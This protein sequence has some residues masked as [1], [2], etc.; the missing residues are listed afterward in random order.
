MHPIIKDLS[1]S[2]QNH[3]QRSGFFVSLALATVVLLLHFPFEGY[4]AEHLV[5]TRYGHGHCPHTATKEEI[6]EFSAEQL[7]QRMEQTVQCTNQYEEQ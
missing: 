4:T 3:I 2:R 1:L 6:M 7:S 5:V